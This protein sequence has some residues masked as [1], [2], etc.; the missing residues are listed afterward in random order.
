LNEPD[1]ISFPEIFQQKSITIQQILKV[2]NRSNPVTVPAKAKKVTVYHQGYFSI[3]HSSNR[4]TYTVTDTPKV[5]SSKKGTP[6]NR[7]K[8]SSFFDIVNDREIRMNFN[9]VLAAFKNMP[10]L[11]YQL[12]EQFCLFI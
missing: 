2:T 4:R 11:I 3:E 10:R 5:P 9:T 6:R 7:R 12:L 8:P 1:E